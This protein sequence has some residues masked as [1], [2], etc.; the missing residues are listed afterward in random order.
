MTIKNNKI[1]KNKLNQVGKRPVHWKLQ[2]I[3]KIKK[4]INEWR[5][6]R[7]WKRDSHKWRKYLQITS[8]KRLI[9]KDIER[10]PTT[11]QKPLTKFKNEQNTWIDIFQ[12]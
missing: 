5:D 9:Y 1:L 6:T 12:R 11:H 10:I 4:N 2:N 8:D 7:K 3:A